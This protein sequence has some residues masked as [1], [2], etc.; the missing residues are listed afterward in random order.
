MK[1]LPG[2][3]REQAIERDQREKERKRVEKLL[4]LAYPRQREAHL[5]KAKM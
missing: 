5:F 1:R 4:R 3:T 2:E